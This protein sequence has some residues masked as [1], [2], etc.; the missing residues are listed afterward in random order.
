MQK[1]R[2][3][4]PRA[5]SRVA[6]MIALSEESV[7]IRQGSKPGDPN[8][9][10]VSCPD[11]L[12]LAC[13]LARSI[14]EFGLEVVRADFSTDG[15]W[16]L[17]L[18]WVTPRQG[19][20]KAIKWAPLKKRLISA[21]PPPSVS[22]IMPYK[23]NAELKR[24]S[25]LLQ[26]CSADR[27]GL[28]NDLAQTLW[29]LEV[30]VQKVNA[31]TSPDGSAVDVFYLTESRKFTSFKKRQED[32][33]NQIKSVLGASPSLCELS[34][35]PDNEFQESLDVGMFPML[36]DELFRESFT[37]FG[38]GRPLSD[39]EFS[40]NID[41]SLSPGH[42]L[43]QIT[44]SDRKGILYDCTRVLRDLSLK[45]AY[46]R[47]S[48]TS[49]GSGD[50]DLFILQANGNK[51]VDPDKLKC[52]SSRLKMDV[53]DP[54]RVMVVNRGPDTEL[55]VATTVEK[56]GRARPRILYDVTLVLK[57]LDIC[58]F[59]ADSEKITYGDRLWEIYRFLLLE[60]SDASFK[61]SR[62]RNQIV[63]RVKSMLMGN[64]FGKR[65]S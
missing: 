36:P 12:G 34:L 57:M 21:C 61:S 22:L 29:E 53:R 51:L 24:D 30:D 64:Q 16:C 59:K 9:I 20:A 49:N 45:I 63:Q 3:N 23:V 2:G 47:L 7:V 58:I 32:V 37:S 38:D 48:T 19:L 10:T 54:I 13:D 25:Y 11:E 40:V 43:L 39:S 17:M 60:K 62:T 46:G 1:Q 18:F 52:L 44:F 56:H 28:I 5:S 27:A 14:F 33:C 55:L 31:L 42:T 8:I 41:N 35:T 15:K 50:L 6:D 4:P 26:T 65:A